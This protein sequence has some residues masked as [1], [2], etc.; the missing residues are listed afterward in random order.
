VIPGYKFTLGLGQIEWQPA[1]LSQTGDQKHHQPKNLGNAKPQMLLRF[2]D[3]CQV[4]RTGQND[5]AHE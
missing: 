1:C 4:K 3:L 2:D 5:H